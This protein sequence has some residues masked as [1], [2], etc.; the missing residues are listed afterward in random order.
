MVLLTLSME[1]YRHIE[2]S[3]NLKYGYKE[4]KFYILASSMEAMQAY[5]LHSPNFMRRQIIWEQPTQTKHKNL[6]NYLYERPNL[7]FYLSVDTLFFNVLA[8]F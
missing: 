3:C 8:K 5:L 7:F 1:K 2:Q 6:T 4:G